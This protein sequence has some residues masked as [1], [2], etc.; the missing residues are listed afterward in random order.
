MSWEDEYRRS[1]RKGDSR[2]SRSERSREGERFSRDGHSWDEGRSVRGGHSRD[3]RR[4]GS[5]YVRGDR[6][7]SREE[8]SLDDG[9]SGGGRS[10]RGEQERSSRRVRGDE[11]SDV[12]YDRHGASRD[13]APSSLTAN[14]SMVDREVYD[15]SHAAIRSEWGSKHAERAA[16][17]AK[18]KPDKSRVRMRKESEYPSHI[19]DGGDHA[20]RDRAE[21]LRSERQLSER[22]AERMDHTSRTEYEGRVGRMGST[23]R[24]D[25][26]SYT[27]HTRRADLRSGQGSQSQESAS[28][29]QTQQ[30]LQNRKTTPYS[31]DSYGRAARKEYHP[32]KKGINLRLV[33]G[34]AIAALLVIVGAFLA[35]N[36]FAGSGDNSSSDSDAVELSV[37]DTK[38]TAVQNTTGASGDLVMNL[39]G[40]ANTIVL[41]GE[42][43]IES[44]CH[45]INKQTGKNVTDKVKTEGSVDTSKVGE[46]TITYSVTDD[47]GAT[48]SKNR[49]VH[50]V[51]SMDVDTDGISV[52]M[53][54]YVY[55]ADDQPDTVDGNYI[56]DTDLDKELAWLQSEDYYYPS[57]QELSAY[58]AGK[59][60]LPKKSVIVTF[61]DGEVGFLKY[62]IPL[63]EK[64]QVPATSFVIASDDDAADKVK[65]YASEYVSFQSHSYA[66]H[67]GGSS[68]GRGGRIH[69]MTQQE[70]LEDLQK[71]AGIVQNNEAMAYPFGDNNET[72]H[73][74]IREA[75]IL[76]AF[77]IIN[78]QVHVGDDPTCLNRVRISGEYSLESFIYSVENGVG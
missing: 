28:R 43:Y 40:D 48:L 21:A 7:S 52:L 64:H 3:D 34:L 31:R 69:A 18:K 12:L 72:A 15:Y 17:Q 47:S 73:A 37:D 9:R 59:H 36:A 67:Q 13:K 8:R 1:D 62:G 54:H 32:Q 11:G 49:N 24:T 4:S 60:S 70:I 27:G 14:R 76:C 78:D 55:T 61:D 16:R 71:A 75:G 77:T 2:F 33:I 23:D 65:N 58:V 46:Y 30:T 25:Q 50:V 57:Y 20:G 26:G 38:Q 29:W 66:M 41:K 6:H 42:E 19:I 39:N 5:G 56:L 45:V 44:G 63:L 10:L 35:V 68:V 74:A 51:D 22:R 53:Y